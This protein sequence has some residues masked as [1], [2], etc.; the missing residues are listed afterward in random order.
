MSDIAKDSKLPTWF[1]CTQQQKCVVSLTIRSY[2]SV[3]LT[4]N[5][6]N[7]LHSVGRFLETFWPTPYQEMSHTWDLHFIITTPVFWE[8]NYPSMHDI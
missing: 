5:N 3:D 8:Q 2:H 6:V 7:N 4:N 1:F